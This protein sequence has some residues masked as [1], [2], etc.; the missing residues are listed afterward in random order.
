M[1]TIINDSN[2]GFDYHGSASLAGG[3]SLIIWT[4]GFPGTIGV[5]ANKEVAATN[6][7]MVSAITDSKESI[8]DDS[9]LAIDLAEANY[10]VDQIVACAWGMSAYQISNAEGSDPIKINWRIIRP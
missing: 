1:A 10:T 5:I 3:A 9:Y 6:A 4:N 8:G 2:Y 7:F